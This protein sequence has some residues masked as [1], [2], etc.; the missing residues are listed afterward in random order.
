MNSILLGIPAEGAERIISVTRAQTAVYEAENQEAFISLPAIFRQE[1]TA[2]PHGV[3]LKSNG[4]A[5]PDGTVR[6]VLLTPRIDKDLEIPEK[7]IHGLPEAFAG[8]FRYFRG[9]YFNGQEVIFILNFKILM[10]NIR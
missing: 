9:A 6:T 8:L 2:V 7:D 3:V 10:E 4:P 5:L 1:D